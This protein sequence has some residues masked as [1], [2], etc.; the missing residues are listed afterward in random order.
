MIFINHIFSYFPNL[1][2][3][4]SKNQLETFLDTDYEKLEFEYSDLK[5]W[6]KNNIL[7]EECDLTEGFRNRGIKYKDDMAVLFILLFYIHKNEKRNFDFE[8][9][10]YINKKR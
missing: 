8:E 9:Y 1:E 7:T 2:K 10:F 3:H 4:F 5:L 6:E